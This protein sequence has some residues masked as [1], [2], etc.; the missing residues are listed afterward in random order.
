MFI[1]IVSAVWFFVHL[2]IGVNLIGPMNLERTGRVLAWG[3]LWAHFLLL[4]IAFATRLMAP[5]PVWYTPFFWVTFTLA[6]FTMILFPLLAV[7][8]AAWAS[9][10]LLRYLGEIAIAHSPADALPD[11]SRRLFI[12]NMINAGIVVSSGALTWAGLVTAKKPPATL[13]VTVPIHGLPEQLD[14]F[15][16]AHITDTH[17]SPTIGGKYLGEIVDRVNRLEPDMISFTGDLVDGLVEEMKDD[18]AHIARLR[19]R[20]GVFFVTGNHEYYWDLDGWLDEIRRHGLTILNNES[21][22]IDHDGA[23]ALV[24]G[25]TDYSAGNH[26]PSHVS[27]PARAVSGAPDCDVRIMLAHQPKSAPAVAKTGVDLQLSGH[28][29]G[30]Q[31]FPWNLIV[32]YFHPV[33]PGLQRYKSMWVYTSRG[34]GHWGPPLRLGSP[35]EITRLVLRPVWG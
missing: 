28:T 20:H 16:V 21:V 12:T 29:H 3:L 25:V 18:V 34:S 17:I 31:F 6:G 33:K 1:V 13:T 11:P 19:A 8:S 10:D 15:T 5:K 2:F 24:A 14:G 32:P 4:P 22:V 27:D 9:L 35:P 30:G 26:V 7:K 23:K